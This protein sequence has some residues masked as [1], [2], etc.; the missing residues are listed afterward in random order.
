MENNV[1]DLLF[2]HHPSDNPILT[3]VISCH[4]TESSP[5][6]TPLSNKKVLVW[7]ADWKLYIHGIQLRRNRLLHLRPS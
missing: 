5:V 1:R 3:V 7:E 6:L 2:I 4:T